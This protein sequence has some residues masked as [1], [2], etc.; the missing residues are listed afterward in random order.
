MEDDFKAQN[1]S[2]YEWNLLISDMEKL[3]SLGIESEES[4]LCCVSLWICQL[5]LNT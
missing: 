3:F 2:V 1:R 5:T 4:D